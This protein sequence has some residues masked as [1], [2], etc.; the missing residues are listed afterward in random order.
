MCYFAQNYWREGGLNNGSLGRNNRKT[1]AL[2]A[3][4]NIRILKVITW[5]YFGFPLPGWNR[6]LPCL[7]D[8]TKTN[9]TIA[10]IP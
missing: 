5:L 6:V 1:G 10:Y 9:H 3:N 8:I 4:M 2:S 7:E